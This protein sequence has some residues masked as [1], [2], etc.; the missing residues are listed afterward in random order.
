MT[1]LALANRDGVVE[2]AMPG[3][4]N[5]ARVSV[6]D[7]EA[8][9]AKFLL[10]DRWSRTKEFEGRRIE[11]VNGGWRL[12]NHGA[13]RRTLSAEARADYQRVKQAEYRKRKRRPDGD[14][15]EKKFARPLANG[16]K[17]LAEHPDD[18]REFELPN[19]PEIVE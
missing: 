16:E 18:K 7:C 13:Y 14:C 4:A 1:M 8:A 6:E 19:A 12:L 3:L 17:Y 5:A 2:A 9:V 10:P 11:V 15:A